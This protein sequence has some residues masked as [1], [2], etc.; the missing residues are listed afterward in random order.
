MAVRLYCLP[1]GMVNL[2]FAM[3]FAQRPTMAPK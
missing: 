2:A 1:L 3:R